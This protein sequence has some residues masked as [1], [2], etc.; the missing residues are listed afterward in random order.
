MKKTVFAVGLILP[1][2]FTQGFA[3]EVLHTEDPVSTS[4]TVSIFAGNGGTVRHNE[5]MGMHRTK[6]HHRRH[7]IKHA[8]KKHHRRAR[9]HSSRMQ[10]AH[11]P[12][13][14]K[15]H[16][17]V[18]HHAIAK[19]HASVKYPHMTHHK[20][21]RKLQHQTK[22]G[23]VKSKPFIKEGQRKVKVHPAQ[24]VQKSHHGQ[25]IVVLKPSQYLRMATQ[26]PAV[27]TFKQPQSVHKHK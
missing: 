25:R 8:A 18:K 13:R 19:H 7:A 1:L 10:R 26:R 23:R 11:K 21:H 4:A 20:G 6:V 12:L 24:R 3:Q 16:A 22:F 14:V 5:S 15:H 27:T 17:T 9:L 2:L